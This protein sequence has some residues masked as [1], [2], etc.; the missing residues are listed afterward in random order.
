MEN[1]YVWESAI[2]QHW[3]NIR[4]NIRRLQN[5]ELPY[6]AYNIYIYMFH[7]N[8]E[9]FERMKNRLYSEIQ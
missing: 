4:T 8:K 5:L 9:N 3:E 6:P 7:V 1:N 2:D